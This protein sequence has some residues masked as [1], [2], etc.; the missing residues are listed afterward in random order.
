MNWLM[1]WAFVVGMIGALFL[2]RLHSMNKYET[3]IREHLGVDPDYY[4]DESIMIEYFNKG[5]EA[6]RAAWLMIQHK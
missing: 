5:I 6:R 4:F 3:A 1:I 2:I